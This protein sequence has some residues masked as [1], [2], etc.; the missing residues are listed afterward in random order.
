MSVVQ[1]IKKTVVR[2]ERISMH[3]APGDGRGLFHVQH[4]VHAADD[5]GV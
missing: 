5:N 2:Y 4:Q 1:A 3:D